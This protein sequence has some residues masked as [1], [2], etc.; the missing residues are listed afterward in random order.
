MSEEEVARRERVKFITRRMKMRHKN[1][2][3][4]SNAFDGFEIARAII[5]FFLRLNETI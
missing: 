3:V 4:M 5:V 2:M 1:A